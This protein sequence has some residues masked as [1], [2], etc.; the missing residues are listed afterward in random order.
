[1]ESKIRTVSIMGDIP[2]KLA[3]LIKHVDIGVVVKAEV[4]KENG[5]TITNGY[6]RQCLHIANVSIKSEGH[7]LRCINDMGCRYIARIM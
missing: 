3:A 6:M 7:R 2:N 1:M 5:D 4:Y